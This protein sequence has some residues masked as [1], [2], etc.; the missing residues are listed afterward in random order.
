MQPPSRGR[1][2]QSGR[3]RGPARWTPWELAL[4]IVS[5]LMIAFPLYAGANRLVFPP[6][7]P[8]Q[9]LTP[10]A[11]SP[12]D[13]PVFPP[14]E[15]P[16][17]P[18]DTPLP[19]PTDT[20]QPAASDTPQ[21]AASDTPQPAASDTPQPPTS[22]SDSTVEQGP[23]RTPTN[24]PIVTPATATNTTVVT[25]ATATSTP[26]AGTPPTATSTSP[27]GTPPTATN[28]VGPVTGVRVFK[29]AS[30]S[31]VAPGQ[32]FSYSISVITGNSVDGQ[33]T[34]EDTVD[35]RLVLQGV[36]T[37]SGSCST[38][39]QSVS[40]NL[41]IRDVNPAS[42]TLQ[43]QV[44]SDVAAGTV[45]TNVA[46]AAGVSSSQASVLVTGAATPVPT[47]TGTPPTS[48]PVPTVTGTPPTS[49]PTSPPT[50]QPVPPSP[51]TSRDDDN[52]ND[53]GD[54]GGQ[55]ESRPRDT[56]VPVA[57][58]APP[59]PN[60]NALPTEPPT[61]GG[62]VAPAVRPTAAVRPT[63]VP[64]GPTNTPSNLIPI[65][66]VTASPAAISP[67]TSAGISSG[68]EIF[69]R[70]A[71]DWGSVYPGQQI[72]FT[73]A[74]R[75]TR[76]PA[77]GGA[78]DVRNLSVRSVLPDNLEVLG[79]D[80]D[81]GQ[82]PARNGNEVSYSLPLL[83]PGEGVEILIA[84]RVKPSVTPG[85]I[86][87]TQGQLTYDG[88]SQGLF[89][90]IVTVQVVGNAQQTAAPRTATV[91]IAATSG[92]AYP[93]P[94]TSTATAGV[95]TATATIR[96]TGP[97]TTAVPTSAQPTVAPSVTPFVYQP[98]PPPAP[99]PNTEAGVPF[100]GILLLG[101]TLLTRTWRLHR[102]K[103]RI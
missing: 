77:A 31:E 79:T 63:R 89:S 93:A 54:S 27:A 41:T 30:R 61:P 50:S 92:T 22:T 28:T 33:V 90:N 13:D 103:E 51:T 70:L 34:L 71:S 23:T 32:Q 20:P 17:P 96:P 38:S 59:T 83:Q 49:Q 48:T 55:A 42:I 68:G 29:V 58:P 101:M 82:D 86:L 40:C 45:I 65:L 88:L 99:L 64:L 57:P 84:S 15:P 87:V 16:P 9:E 53:N 35:S 8:A 98:Q 81:R 36:S 78:N 73:L 24:T 102:A 97:T 72:N 3:G 62:I 69:F 74:V 91:G 75:N 10:P 1:S 76:P 47:V 94:A 39:G 6:V 2:P 11:A 4:I 52:D 14:T 56:E 43:V 67:T 21:P 26:P 12:T 66:D 37:G 85:T 7:A 18:T 60:P 19:P 44:R 95:A 80:A 46:S 100:I 25:P 5:V